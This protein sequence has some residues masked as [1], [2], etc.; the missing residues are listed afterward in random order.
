MRKM[1]I[2]GG[3]AF[4]VLAMRLA[5][6]YVSSVEVVAVP[7]HE[8]AIADAIREAQPDVVVIDA[9]GCPQRALQRVAEAR[10]ARAEALVVL[11]STELDADLFEEAADRGAL[12]CFG[13]TTFRLQLQALLADPGQ[14]GAAERHIALAAVNGRR[15]IDVQ[16]RPAGLELDCP[17]TSRELEILRAVAQGHGNARIG[18]DL[19]ISEQTVKFHLSKIYRKLGVSNRTEASR[20]V[21]LHDLLASRRLRRVATL[22]QG[23][24]SVGSPWAPRQ[25]AERAVSHA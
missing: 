1:F 20:Y 21:L 18:R 13:T 5:L 17:L 6:R 12:V 11:T 4:L 10:E 23:A 15:S 8:E 22:Q 9:G 3:D 14:R 16:D 2:V 24:G 19:W 25:G 7:D